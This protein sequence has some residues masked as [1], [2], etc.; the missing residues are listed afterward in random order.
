[1][2]MEPPLNDEPLNA[3]NA[4]NPADPLN[5]PGR[6]RS[7]TGRVLRAMAWSLLGV[8]VLCVAIVAG[9]WWW[10]GTNESLAFALTRAARYMPAG[11]TLESRDVS[12]SVL[13]G[14]RIG[15]L[16]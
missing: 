9:A 10:L 6:K 15:W 12:G 13:A 2:T 16:R 3:A 8:V 7:P 14:G 5:P 1:M 11:Q 4:A